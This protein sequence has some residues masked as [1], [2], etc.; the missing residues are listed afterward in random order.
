MIT[1][2][3]DTGLVKIEKWEDIEALPNFQINLNPSD[4]KLE[5]IIGRYI[6]KEKIRCGLSNCHAPHNKGYIVKTKEGSKTNIGKD[7]GKTY[8]GVD[9]ETLSNK[10]DRDTTEAEN[11]DKLWSF[12]FKI[13]ELQEQIT[14]LR[15]CEKGADWVYKKTR[16]LL[17]IGADCPDEIARHIQ[18][19]TKSRT[20]GLFKSREATD[21]E[22]ETLEITQNKK[23]TKPHFIDEKIADLIGLE[24]LYPENDLKNLLVLDLEHNIKT[25]N[26]A[27]IDLLTFEELKHWSKWIG[28][29]ENILERV[30]YSIAAGK[31]LL[32][33]SN[34]EP[35]TSVL[36]KSNDKSTFRIF[37]KSLEN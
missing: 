34:L 37:L 25:L 33:K 9:F 10:Y 35:L 6:F 20:S 30:N 13:E 24:A 36:T 7:C 11:R 23:I 3:T 22:I 18:S 2:N 14:R 16:S 1:L 8:F 17:N 27:D 4:H 5:S 32:T 21:S 28:S 15:Q 29:I 31:N 19:L 26:G 12:S